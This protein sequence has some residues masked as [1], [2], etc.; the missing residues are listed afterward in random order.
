MFSPIT[1]L[2]SLCTILTLTTCFDWEIESFNF[3]ST[4]L[5]GILIEDEK[6]YM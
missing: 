2:A 5:N 4:Y 6:V 1:R 3:N